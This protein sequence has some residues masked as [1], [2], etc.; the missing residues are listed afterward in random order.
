MNTEKLN[1]LKQVRETY[2]IITVIIPDLPANSLERE[3]L[4]EAGNELESLVWNIIHEDIASVTDQLQNSAAKLQNISD[5]LKSVND[6]L[7]DISEKIEK[8]SKVVKAIADMA[9]IAGSA[10]LI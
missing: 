1:T 4:E 2:N 3:K 8:T 6:N 10:G 5:N 9:S 7:N